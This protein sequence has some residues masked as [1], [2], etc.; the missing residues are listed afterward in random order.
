MVLTAAQVT[1][2]FEYEDHME[3]T[4]RT[5]NISL[6][7]EGITTVDELA[8]CK[9]DE[10]YQWKNNCKKPDKIPDPANPA[11]LIHQI[12]FAISVK[13]LKRLKAA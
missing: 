4:N 5:R 1:S 6:N 12:P 13:S 10:W 9:D 3:L 2:F 7:T 11:N 8:E